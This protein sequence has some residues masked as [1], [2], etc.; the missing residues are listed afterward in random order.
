MMALF[1]RRP[2]ATTLLTLGI[3]LAGFVGLRQLPVAPL[4]Q[5]EYPNISVSA[6]LPGASPEIMASSVATPL[7][8]ALGRIAGVTEITSSSSLGSVRINLE[9]DLDRDIDGAARDVQAAINAARSTLPTGLPSNPT[10]RKVNPASA[11]I[12]ILALTSNTMRRGELYDYASTILAQ[13]IAQVRGIGEVS[14]GGSSLPAVRVDI[15]PRALNKYDL[16]LDEVR[17]AIAS[18]NVNR[19][20]GALAGS[21][22]QWQ[23]AANDQ[24]DSAEDFLPMIIRYR[25]AAAVRLGDV[26]EVTDS[27]QDVRNAGLSDGK[28]AVLLLVRAQ[29]GGNIIEA[30]DRVKELMPVLRASVPAAIDIALVQDRT[31]GIRASIYVVTHTLFIAIA[32]VI[33]VV[34]IFLRDWRATMIP[35]IAVPVSLIGTFAAMYLCGYSLN[36]L[37]LMALTIATG[38]VVDDAIVV[39]ENV[40][41]QLEAGASRM[42]AALQ[43]AREVSFTVL[44]MSLSLV[45]VFIPILFMGG[46]VGRFFR[47]FAVTLSVA[48]LVSLVVSLTLVPML[49]ARWLRDKPVQ[50][51]RVSLAFERAFTRMQNGYARTLHWALRFRALMLVLLLATISLNV[52]LYVVIPKGFFPQQDI[53]RIAGSIQADQQISFQ[54][55]QD[56]LTH[57]MDI[58]RR[59][60]A[61]ESVVGFTGG[62]RRNSGVMFLA[63]K[64]VA[65][66]DV[67]TD[68]VINRLREQLKGEPG[69]QL[70]LQSV[71]DIRIGGRQGNAQ[72]QYTLQSDNLKDLRDW[73][74]QIRKALS[75]LPELQDVN[76]DEEDRGLQT[77]LVIDRDTAARLGISMAQIN[78]AL[79]NAFGQRLVSV[80]YNP[81]N[82]YRVVME[83]APEFSADARALHYIYVRAADG[84]QVPLSSFSRYELT[85]TALEV[86]HQA[87]FAATTVTF[88]L[89]DGISLGEATEL[90]RDTFVSIGVPASVQ[91]AFAG[92]AKVFQQSLKSQPWL[93]LATLLAVYIVLGILYESLLHPLT[94]LSTLPSAGVGALLALLAM[95]QDLNLIGIIG[96]ILLIGIVKKNAIM[97]ID[98]ALMAEREQGLSAQDAIFK[99]C[100]MRLR[101][102][103]MTTMAALL[104]AVPLA[105]GIGEGAE[106]RQ[107]LGIAIVGGLM[108]SQLLTL[109][110]TPVVYLYMDAAQRRWWKR[111]SAS[112]PRL[113]TTL[114]QG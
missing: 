37:S 113:A 87:Q 69:A 83:L 100:Q 71:Q 70:F 98:F 12:M 77:S 47:E 65:E 33:L 2:V 79:N 38:F 78:S 105:V 58:V 6:S 35:A 104:G 14:V 94:I 15:D 73:A 42:Q 80:I 109:Y 84:T 39:V 21:E 103:L 1:V 110:T 51:G 10:Y 18:N 50:P 90:I 95:G 28:P 102:I 32:L 46:I 74:P 60:P 59:D 44:A 8:R 25:N 31:V 68:E 3:V 56:K 106:L 43:G 91:G 66:R 54:S 41:R 93:I 82:Q 53:G 107:P 34:F 63:L 96:V 49:C 11:P 20:K 40:T 17:N 24:L 4:P 76:T 85:R 97:M 9:F 101:P 75:Q 22:Q 55:M 111:G 5:V 72:Y 99:A 62:G 16:D 81:L 52:Y 7:E 36:T 89:T 67:S 30:V 13:K 23:I 19:P 112:Q 29:P 64:P 114:G 61:V 45:A 108:V 88:N 48:I 26:A 86:N 57:F 92:T 27:V